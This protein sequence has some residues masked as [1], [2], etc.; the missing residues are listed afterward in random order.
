MI[1][2]EEG[3]GFTA[4]PKHTDFHLTTAEIPIGVLKQSLTPAKG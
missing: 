2:R 1:V 3:I 4:I